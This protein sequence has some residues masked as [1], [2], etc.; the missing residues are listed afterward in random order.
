[1]RIRKDSFFIF[2]YVVSIIIIGFIFIFQNSGLGTYAGGSQIK[3]KK[4]EI[5]HSVNQEIVLSQQEE[6]IRESVYSYF[7]V[8]KSPSPKLLFG[9]SSILSVKIRNTGNTTWFSEGDAPVF[10]GSS[11]PIDRSSLFF[12]EGSNGWFSSNRIS[13]DK[14]RVRPGE[15][16]NFTFHITA[17]TK[18]GVYREF[19][20]PVIDRVKWLSDEDL[21]WDVEVKDPFKLD[22]K[23]T[24]T[25][26]GFPEKYIKVKLSEQNLY[27]Y[28]NGLPIFIFQ[29]STG[30]PGM[31]TP[32][33]EFKIWNKFPSQYSAQY[34]LYMDNWMAFTQNGLYG[35]HSLPYWKMRGGGRLYEG[36]D[37]LGTKVSH[38]C[39][40]VS[41][42][43]SKT[44]YNWTEVGVPV[45]IED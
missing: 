11:R 33:G 45:Y 40:R 39:I 29:T 44:L 13:M 42:E 38:G 27:A 19:F 20:A 24:L 23:L 22:E 26:G 15:V 6:S 2:L 28:E 7:I 37:H 25:V 1:M 43:N 30:K 18:S 34:E 16:V 10:L 41:L 32:K 35:I 17:P 8:S 5:V 3:E 4:S 14:K 21:Y 36:E 9:E 12:V 31:D